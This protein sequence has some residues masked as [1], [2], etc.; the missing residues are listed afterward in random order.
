MGEVYGKTVE[1]SETKVKAP[2]TVEILNRAELEKAGISI[3]LMN[4]DTP[5]EKVAY[6]VYVDEDLNRG[7]EKTYTVKAKVSLH[8]SATKK[9]TPITYNVNFKVK[10]EK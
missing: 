6:K 3:D 1:F 4:E 9:G 5:S 2:I 8:N 10:L 7:Q